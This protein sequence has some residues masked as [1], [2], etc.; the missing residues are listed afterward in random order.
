MS[1]ITTNILNALYDVVE[2]NPSNEWAAVDLW[3]HLWNKHFFKGDDWVV[4]HENPPEGRGRRRVDLVI[5][6]L[7][8]NQKLAVLAFHEAKAADARPSDL[9][10]VE[11]QALNACMRYLGANGELSC[12]Y[13]ITTYGTKGRVWEY[14][15]GDDYLTALFGPQSL[16]DRDS[17]IDLASDDARILAGAIRGISVVLPSM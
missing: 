10:D 6:F 12:V 1:L 7:G 8:E 13:A 9:D 15:R 2:E 16:S 14:K 5:K 3:T 11:G 17:Y 4:S